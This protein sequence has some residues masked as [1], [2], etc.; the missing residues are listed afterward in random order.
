MQE[1]EPLISASLELLLQLEKTRSD[2]SR[3]DSDTHYLSLC[4]TDLC[5]VFLLHSEM[6][7]EPVPIAC[8]FAYALRIPI[9]VPI[10]L[11]TRSRR[12]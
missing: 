2:S 7:R 1:H 4:F 12:R 10:P 9:P 6:F 11:L 5:K 8:T 3:R